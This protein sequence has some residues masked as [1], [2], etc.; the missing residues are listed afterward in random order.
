MTTLVAFAAI[1]FFV[2]VL[3]SLS[4]SGSA[5]VIGGAPFGAE[6]VSLFATDEQIRDTDRSRTRADLAAASD[7]AAAAD[8]IAR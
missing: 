7:L 4:R 5:P 8:R 3:V 2:A 6:K 1:A